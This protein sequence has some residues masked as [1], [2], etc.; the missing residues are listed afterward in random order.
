MLYPAV[1]LLI[2]DTRI[3]VASKV[4]PLF[5]FMYVAFQALLV[6]P[7]SLFHALHFFSMRQ[8]VTVPLICGSHN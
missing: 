4:A 2:Y 6:F 5:K 1:H 7:R 3:R 8:Q